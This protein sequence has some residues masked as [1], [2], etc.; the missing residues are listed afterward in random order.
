MSA[1]APHSESAPRMITAWTN[2]DIAWKP[3]FSSSHAA[4]KKPVGQSH[5][6]GP[7][8]WPPLLQPFGQTGVAQMEP[9]C[10]VLLQLQNPG[11]EHRPKLAHGGLHTGMWQRC[12]TYWPSVGRQ[13][14]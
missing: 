12:P 10:P 7:T 14:H 1:T 8:H 11:A 9:L 13:S 4:P 2:G 3:C 5:R 6:L